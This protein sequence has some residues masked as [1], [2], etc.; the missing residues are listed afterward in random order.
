M[1][2]VP[3]CIIVFDKNKP[4]SPKVR[5]LRGGREIPDDG[6]GSNRNGIHVGG[7]YE[8]QDELGTTTTTT[9]TTTTRNKQ[10]LRPR[11]SSLSLPYSRNLDCG[12]V[13]CCD[14]PPLQQPL[15]QLSSLF[16]PYCRN[17]HWGPVGCSNPPP[18]QQPFYKPRLWPR[19][20]LYPPPPPPT[21]TYTFIT[22]YLL[23]YIIA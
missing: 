18:P 16:L 11:P 6:D 14:P 9:T 23:E 15:C 2:L 10:S 17:L 4:F 20:L 1:V 22:S 5:P 21:T 3:P 7:H 13:R 19:W 12:P 8:S